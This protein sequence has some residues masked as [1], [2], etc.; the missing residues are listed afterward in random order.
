MA[1]RR[2]KQASG[3]KLLLPVL[4]IG[5]VGVVFAA[6]AVGGYF[7][8]TSAKAGINNPSGGGQLGG[9]SRND[10]VTEAEDF[11]NLLATSTAQHAYESTSPAYKA[12]TPLLHFYNFIDSRPLLMS[13]T[14]RRITTTGTVGGS[15]PN[16]KQVLVYELGKSGTKSIRV[17]ITVAEQASGSWKVDNLAAP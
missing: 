3:N 16:R 11:L 8:F 12:S 5:A 17:T 14:G 15:A 7:A 13:H 1:R 10:G 2:K 4:A 6:C 9:N